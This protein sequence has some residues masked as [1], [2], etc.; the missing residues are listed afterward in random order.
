MSL[1][2]MTAIAILLFSVSKVKILPS[3]YF[4]TLAIL[5]FL[6][7]IILTLLL[8]LP[9]K[10]GRKI[11][12]LIACI[13]SF[14]IILGCGGL[15]GMAGK[16][17][18]TMQ[19]ITNTT[20]VATEYAVYVRT[21]DPA[22]ELK[23]IKNYQI[24]ISYIPG[25]N[26]LSKALTSLENE[27][28][29][30]LSTVTFDNVPELV[31]ALYRGEIHAIIL[32]SGYVS[33]FEELELYADFYSRSRAVYTLCVEEI[34]TPT[35]PSTEPPTHNTNNESEEES[36]A[37]DPFVLYI[38]GSD[39]RS[40]T[41][42]RSRSDV[43]IL[44]VVNP[45]IKQI[46]LINTPRGFYVPN[47]AGNGALDKLTHCGI[48]GIDCSIGSLSGLYNIS[49]DHYARINFTGFKTL[50]D[51]IDGVTVYSD[52]AFSG[53]S[54]TFQVGPNELDGAKALEFARTRYGVPGGDTT[55]GKHQMKVLS[56]I[57]DKLSTTSTLITNYSEIMDS[58]QGMFQTNMPQELISDLIKLQL[59]DISSW[60]IQSYSVTGTSS[61]QITFSMPGQ[62]L[63]VKFP[64]METIEHATNLINRVM[65]GENL[66]PSDM[67]LPE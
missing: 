43:N 49:I 28:G 25:D 26:S 20:I 65:A 29:C 32:D 10:K 31:N 34:L 17:Y 61:S 53:E 23:D 5:L 24:G 50:V 30:A 67:V 8:V 3:K 16:L 11:R 62:Y 60:N 1:L 63:S 2:L 64:N 38:S 19:T 42:V 48:Y 40:P 54:F 57:I 66:Q 47:P 36:T 27:I 22:K 39:T 52:L 45:Q 41:L 18:K 51:A 12:A 44:A 56:A 46:L 4:L 9:S 6:V 33:L 13:L 59:S 21:E 14:V 37:I 7:W 55:R 15:T 35:E 58:L